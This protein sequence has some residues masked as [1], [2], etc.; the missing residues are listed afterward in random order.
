M[1]GRIQCPK[2]QSRFQLPSQITGN[3]VW[4][5]S[6][7]CALTRRPAAPP[8]TEAPDSEPIVDGSPVR[9]TSSVVAPRRL[10]TSARTD[11]PAAPGQESAASLFQF[12]LPGG[13]AA[14]NADSVYPWRRPSRTWP[15]IVAALLATGLIAGLF[16]LIAWMAD[17]QN[18]APATDSQTFAEAPEPVASGPSEIE[19]GDPGAGESPSPDLAP[20]LP[21]VVET[22][23]YFS[24]R[25][26]D[27]AWQRVHGYLVRL[28]IETPLAGRQATGLIV[29]SRGWV[30]T[31]LS[32][33]RDAAR[34]TVTVAAKR[35]DDEPQWMVLSDEAR[36]IIATDPAN[37]LAI[38]AI[39]RSQVI[40]LTDPVL[41]TEDRVVPAQ[42]LLIARTP[43]PRHRPWLT[44]CRIER[45]ASFPELDPKWQQML[46]GN[47][48][49]CDDR[50]RWVIYA[51]KQKTSLAPQLAGSPILDLQGTVVAFNTGYSV[52]NAALAVPAESVAALL[53]SISGQPQARPFARS[54]E[55]NR[56]TGGTAPGGN[57]AAADPND[58]F[59]RLVAQVEEGIRSCRATDWS[60]DDAT[61]YTTFQNLV[62]DIVT[63]RDWLASNSPD[64][65]QL[66]TRTEWVQNQMDEI[67]KSMTDDIDIDEF[68]SGKSNHWFATAINPDNPWCVLAVEVYQDAIMTGTVDNVPACTLKIL[69][70][71]EIIVAPLLV[72]G[73]QYR[74]GRK[75]LIFGKVNLDKQFRLRESGEVQMAR[76]V[77]VHASFWMH[78][79]TASD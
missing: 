44:E 77:D 35:L 20:E 69:G 64:D 34:V 59:S 2:C 15:G 8:N 40:N 10:Q 17:G 6:C 33:I 43:P 47:D 57:T 52:A 60:A 49:H 48:L 16:L 29:D 1:T 28:D 7:G 4:C 67:V 42:R 25:Q 63:A 61:E 26:W 50:F 12:D 9:P 45:R 56:M 36:G 62:R 55:L 21:P 38:I 58:E 72:D 5:P 14:A 22:P 31:S 53:K 24:R 66:A 18:R 3:R 27:Q 19:K 79:G 37:D 23:E 68:D 46:S 70:T 39:N 13:V 11:P 71:N 74:K 75:F 51:P 65:A 78:E 30:V 32:A 73:R 54:G 76:V 41:A